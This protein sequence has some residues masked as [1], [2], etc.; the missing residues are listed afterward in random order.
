MELK[1]ALPDAGNHFVPFDDDMSLAE[2]ILGERCAEKLED[3]RQR[4]ALKSPSAV[5]FK[6]RLAYRSFRVV[7]NGYTRPPLP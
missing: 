4:L 1:S 2:V 6:G 7:L 5:A 3:V